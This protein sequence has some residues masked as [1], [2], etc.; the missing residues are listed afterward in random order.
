MPTP[1]YSLK[2]ET[3]ACSQKSVLI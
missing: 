2:T 1:S 3:A